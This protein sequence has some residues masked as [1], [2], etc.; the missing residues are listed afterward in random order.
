[1]EDSRS[2]EDNILKLVKAYCHLAFFLEWQ[3]ASAPSLFSQMPRLPAKWSPPLVGM[4]KINFDGAFTESNPKAGI[5]V[6]IRDDKGKLLVACSKQIPAG[7]NAHHIKAL[8]TMEA[9]RLALDTGFQHVLLE[10]DALM[11][12]QAIKNP[13]TN[14][15][16][17]GHILE[18]IKSLCGSFASCFILHVRREGNGVAHRLAKDAYLVDSH[19]IWMEDGLVWIHPLLSFDSL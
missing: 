6:V 14:L 13:N 18:G 17:V 3:Q 16:S 5:G 15:S 19:R 11:I 7:I 12:V 4:V 9:F 10:G 8:T 2:K 1:M